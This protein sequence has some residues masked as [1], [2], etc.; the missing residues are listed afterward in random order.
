MAALRKSQHELHCYPEDSCHYLRQKLSQLFK[1]DADAIVIGNGSVELIM[2][3]CL[4]YLDPGDELM[5][6]RGAFI[7]P[8]IGAAVMNGKVVEVEPDNYRHNLRQMA[9]SVTQRTKIIYLDNPINPLGTIVTRQELDNFLDRIPQGVLV[10]LDEAY[11]EYITSREYPRSLDYYN[12]NR[13]VLI[14]RTM[15]KAYGLAGLRVGYGFARP[16]I[17]ASLAKVRLPFNV[18]RAAQAAAVAALEDGLHVKRSRR[19]NE[20]G[21]AMF[22]REF[23]RLKL[24]YLE[25]YANFVFV[26]FAIDAQLVF[27]E[28][29]R[30]GVIARTVR[31]YGFP[32]ALRV[33]V[34][35][36]PQNRRFLKALEEVMKILVGG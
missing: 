8:K 6:T 12:A 16:E 34:G 4:A 3:A 14:L 28:L 9:E 17:A 23:K 33:S 24:F 26:N 29:Q 31:E 20:A 11:A 22:Y 18:S 32:N 19:L 10:I 2:L 36:E 1:V 7:M 25:S 13:N 35:T 5:M 21:K 30:R 27:E 15:S